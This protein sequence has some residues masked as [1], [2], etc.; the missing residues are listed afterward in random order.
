M[1]CIR[2]VFFFFL[3]TIIID[4]LG[5]HFVCPVLR[6]RES[7]TDLS[8]LKDRIKVGLKYEWLHAN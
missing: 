5:F 4:N 3:L 6:E 8:G 7:D 2:Y 1:Q